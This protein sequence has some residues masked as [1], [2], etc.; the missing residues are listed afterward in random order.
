MTIRDENGF[1]LV[2]FDHAS[3][4][5][6]WSYFDGVKTVYRTDYPVAEAIKQNTFDRN[7]ATGWKGDWHRV[8]SIPLNIIHDSGMVEA[9]SQQDDGF[10]SRWLN[11]SD[12]AA[13]RTKEGNL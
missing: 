5:S 6:V 3:G 11:D 4:R 10:M 12:N 8:A 7:E 1:T 9:A 2:D 13:W